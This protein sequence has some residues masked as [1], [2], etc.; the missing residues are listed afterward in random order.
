MLQKI[1]SNYLTSQKSLLRWFLYH[2]QTIGH[3][4]FRGGSPRVPILSSRL[5][6]IW[7]LKQQISR[8]SQIMAKVTQ[9]DADAQ[10]LLH[11]Q[12]VIAVN[13]LRPRDMVTG[14]FR[15]KSCIRIRYKN[16]FFP[17]SLRKCPRMIWNSISTL[18]FVV[19]LRKTQFC[20]R[21]WIRANFQCFCIT[22]SI[23]NN[24]LSQMNSS[25]SG[26]PDT[27][28]WPHRVV[29]HAPKRVKSIMQWCSMRVMSM[30]WPPS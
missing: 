29:K 8:K 11:T 6:H 14:H 5:Y 7:G 1:H 28:F 16:N 22:I 18:V 3:A 20:K 21:R 13:N 15:D 27:R 12:C 25:F 19:F 23:Y 10:K 24:I 30:E 26:V 9:S 2:K 4:T 17:N